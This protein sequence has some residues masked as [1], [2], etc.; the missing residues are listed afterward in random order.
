MPGGRRAQAVDEGRG[1]EESRAA[2]TADQSRPK[3]PWW[4][5]RSEPGPLSDLRVTIGRM[6]KTRQVRL[7]KD[8][9]EGGLDM[10]QDWSC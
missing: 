1:R 7:A 8:A 9:M 6:D 10:D 5:S 2:V 4:S 3:S